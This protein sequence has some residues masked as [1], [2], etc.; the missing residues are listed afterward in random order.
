VNIITKILLFPIAVIYGAII[1]FR[2]WL[3]KTNFIGSTDFEIP[4]I[5]VGNL[6]VGGTGKTPFIELL[7]ETIAQQYPIGVLSRGYKRKT[8]GYR[9]VQ[10][11]STS[12]EVGDE[13]LMLKLKY[14]NVFV[15]VGEQR[16]IAIP[17]MLSTH[18]Y[19]KTILLDDAFQHQSVRP[20]INILLTTYHKPFYEDLILPLGTLREFK[21]GKV[22]ANI[23]VVTKCPSDL[24]E[25]E[26]ATIIKKIAPT[27]TQKIFFSSIEYGVPYHILQPEEHYF[28]DKNQPEVLI[29]GIANATSLLSFLANKT[30][31]IIHYDFPDHHYF[32]IKE[33]ENIK[34]QYPDNKRWF[35]TEKDGVR[36]ASHKDWLI[37]NGISL[38]CIPIKTRI[39]GNGASDF[40]NTIKGFLSYYYKD[41]TD[42]AEDKS[43][44]AV[45]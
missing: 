45:D 30:A 41:D 42:V 32:E 29:T 9:E 34:Q 5:S 22:R 23:I 18:P 27:T 11:N 7:I 13:P 4:V 36:L 33:L 20:D 19:I 40:N 24:S 15:S 39:I 6:S 35:C 26:Q 17:Q 16:V 31:D 28:F 3:Y 44:E 14:P 12:L 37:A 10:I 1:T 21:S 2:N 43:I 8:S 38:Y 25:Q